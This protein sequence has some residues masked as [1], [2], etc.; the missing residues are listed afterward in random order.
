M[1]A[2]QGPAA[3]KAL[4]G[5]KREGAG[6]DNSRGLAQRYKTSPGLLAARIREI[7]QEDTEVISYVDN[8]YI[9]DEYMSE[10]L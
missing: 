3:M 9:V 2:T 6:E 10:Q 4:H 1:N 5:A 8:I 7:L